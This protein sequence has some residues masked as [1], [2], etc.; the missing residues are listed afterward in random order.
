MQ[1]IEI[2]CP[3]YNESEGLK[4]F[5]SNLTSE[6]KTLSSHYNWKILFVN[7]PKSNEDQTWEIIKSLAQDESR[8]SGIRMTKRFGIQASIWAGIAHS[9]GDIVI[10]MDS[11]GQHPPRLIHKMLESHQLGN[12]VVLTKRDER[13]RLSV[14]IFY[15]LL[16][17]LSK[18]PPADAHSDFRLLDRSVVNELVTNFHEIQP[19]LRSLMGYWGSVP[20]IKFKV[21]DRIAGQTS[22]TLLRSYNYL[23]D[24]ILS[25]GHFPFKFICPFIVLIPFLFGT[26][27]FSLANWYRGFAWYW[28]GLV[29]LFLSMI[30]FN[31][32]IILNHSRKRPVYI[33]KERVN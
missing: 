3:V 18:H 17:K 28:G 21:E 32:E 31:L 8:I 11:D 15:F 22:F 19:F 20:V 25:S 30:A 9:T 24:I 7:D 29:S 12:Q 1:T 27:E 26:Y 5:A 33:I 4:E 10:T 14:T 23:I 16:N 2:I 13:P 6:L